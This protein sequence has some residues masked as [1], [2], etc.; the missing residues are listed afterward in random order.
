MQVDDAVRIFESSEVTHGL[1]AR[2]STTVET[3]RQERNWIARLIVLEANKQNIKDKSDR[4]VVMSYFKIRS[5]IEIQIQ[6]TSLQSLYWH[7]IS[8]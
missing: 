8:V 2:P 7:S 3:M 5:I 6:I 4:V 1:F